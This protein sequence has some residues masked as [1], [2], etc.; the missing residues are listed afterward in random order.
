MA[1]AKNEAG[2]IAQKGVTL[3][4]ARMNP[5]ISIAS[6]NKELKALMDS[7][8]DATFRGYVPELLKMFKFTKKGSKRFVNASR[9]L[10]DIIR[11][12]PRLGAYRKEI[13]PIVE[14]HRQKC[15]IKY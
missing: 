7:M 5:F 6:Y 13:L 11:Q 9:E 15:G 10:D 14:T 3:L 8:S 2:M 4:L 1:I 12:L